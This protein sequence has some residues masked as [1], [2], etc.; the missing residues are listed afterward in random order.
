MYDTDHATDRKNAAMVLLEQSEKNIYHPERK[1][2]REYKGYI[3][4]R[5]KDH[6]LVHIYG[7][8]GNKSLLDGAGYTDF[9]K[10]YAAIDRLEK[11]K[12]TADDTNKDHSLQR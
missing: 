10:A 3:V 6:T 8:D 5:G 1:E 11:E 7:N 2:H 9:D 12:E 4:K